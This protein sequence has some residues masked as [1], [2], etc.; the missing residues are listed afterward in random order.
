VGPQR[1]R[2]TKI[3]WKNVKGNASDRRDNPVRRAR[4]RLLNLVTPYMTIFHFTSLASYLYFIL[5][6]SAK[7]EEW[8]YIDCFRSILSFKERH[9]R[10][11]RTTCDAENIEFGEIRTSVRC[12]EVSVLSV[13]EFS[14]VV[15]VDVQIVHFS[16]TAGPSPFN[17]S[18]FSLCDISR[19]NAMEACRAL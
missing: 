12:R 18:T 1:E 3:V 19:V 6:A 5:T 8:E 10:K 13:A 4:S 2:Y 17:A 11:G 14:I 7:S 9:S 15:A 16:F